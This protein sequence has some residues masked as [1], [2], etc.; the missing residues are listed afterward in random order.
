M[1]FLLM[2]HGE[3]SPPPEIDLR[4]IIE[5]VDAFD[6]ELTRAGQN[7][8]SIRLQPSSTATTLS[9]KKGKVLTTDG[10]FVES[11]EQLGGIYIIEADDRNRA[12]EIARRLPMTKYG[13][14]EIRPV[15]GIDLRQAI[16]S[17]YDA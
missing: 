7:L 16:T 4:A 1:H 2:I 11:K 12:I 13:S 5:A 17:H 8:G 6:E 9:L 3:E 15:L 14:V 10:P